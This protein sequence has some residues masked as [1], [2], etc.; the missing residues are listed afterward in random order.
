M[1]WWPA[2]RMP[3]VWLWATVAWT[4]YLVMGGRWVAAVG[5]VCFEVVVSFLG[6]RAMLAQA[7]RHYLEFRDAG[8]THEQAAAATFDVHRGAL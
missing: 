1:G 4:A 2:Y 6:A 8:L 7:Q 3:R 5:V